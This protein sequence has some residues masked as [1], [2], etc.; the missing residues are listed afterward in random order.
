MRISAVVP[1]LGAA[2]HL[3][4]CLQS[5]A[6]ADEIVIADGGSIASTAAI[7]RQAGVRFVEAPRGRGSQLAAGAAAASGDFLLFVHSDTRLSPGWS[8]IA[9]RHVARSQRP[10]CFRLRLDDQA[11][12]A[13]VIEL[14]VAF[15]TRWFGLP[16]GD[17]GLLISREHYERSGGFRPL[18]L[19]EDVELLQ[20]IGRPVMLDAEALTSAE[21]WRRDGWARRSLR[22][23]ACYWLWRLGVSPER[24]EALY[25]RPRR[26]S[27]SPPGHAFPAE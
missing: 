6:E 5:L 2:E 12:Q 27:P 8:A 19:M 22:N 7:A 3:P 9:R 17:Q 13:R 18:P 15:R 4:A 20:R 24:I 14:A 10:A 1:T 11:W 25:D 23:L 21:R 16:Y 26:V